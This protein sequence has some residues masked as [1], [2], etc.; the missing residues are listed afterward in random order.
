MP[1]TGGIHLPQEHGREDEDWS[2]WPPFFFPPC[3]GGS[4]FQA[5]RQPIRE[6][7]RESRAFIPQPTERSASIPLATHGC[8][9]I[10]AVARRSRELRGSSVTRWKNGQ[11]RRSHMAAT[12]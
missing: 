7:H 3:G 6:G 11:T 2:Q 10:F 4:G 1:P 5:H 9:V 8:C 12:G